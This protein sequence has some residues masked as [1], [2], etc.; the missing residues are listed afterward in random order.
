MRHYK[1]LRNQE[2]NAEDFSI[3]PIQDF[4]I[5][6]IR[7]WRNEQLDVLRQKKI[8]SKKDQI[9]YFT[10]HIWPLFKQESP[11]QILFSF[12]EGTKFIGYGGLV[13]LSWEDKRAEMSFLV[14]PE[15]SNKN[16]AYSNCLLSFIQLS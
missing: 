3:R 16:E 4:D 5:E 2:F 7:L 6:S 13:H 12:F 9:D 14:D 10:K 11:S 8:I 15:I 1:C